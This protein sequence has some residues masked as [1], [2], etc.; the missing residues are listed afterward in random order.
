MKMLLSIMGLLLI[1]SELH[2]QL[3]VGS[4]SDHLRYNKAEKIAVSSDEIFASTGSSILVYNKEF[5][6][7][8]KLSPVTGLSETGIS[9]IAWSVQNQVLII[10]YNSANIDLVRENT[11]FNIPEILNKYIPGEK[12]INRITTSGKYAFLATNF[13]IVVVDLIKKEIHDTW[14]PGPGPETN[15]VFD[16]TFGNNKVFAATAIGVWAGD[17]TSQG[18]A[19]FGN[20]DQE[21]SL[22][23]PYIKCTLVI[24]SGNKLY[25]NVSP[26]SSTGDSIFALD[27]GATLVSYTPGLLNRS[28]DIAP[29]GF[30]VSSKGLL[31]YFRSDGSVKSTI[32]SYGW[33][34]PD[35]SQAIIESNDIWLADLNFGLIKAQN[36]SGFT[37]LTLPGPASNYAGNITY[38]NNTVL[39]SAGGADNSWMSLGRAFQV[40]LYESNNFTNLVPGTVRD[41]MRACIDPGNNGHFFISSW[42]D[43]LFEYNNNTLVKHFNENNTPELA[44][45]SGNTGIRICGL[46]MDRSKNLWIAQTGNSATIKVLKPDGSWIVNPL[47]I[48]APVAGDIIAAAN[49]QKWMVLPMGYSMF[50]LDDNNTPEVFTDDTSG[51]LI[52]KDSDEKVI[53][54][55]FS[56]A[57][58]LDGNI[59]IGTDQGPIIY[60]NPDRIFEIDARGERIKVPRND[61]S[62][63]A[64]YMLGT[65]TITSISIDGANRKWLGTRSSGVYLLSADGT[66]M[67]K[68]YNT[69]N[70]PL[71]SD[72]I[73]SVAVDNKT[74]EVWFGT[75]EGVLSVREIAISGEQKFTDVYAFPNP[76]RENYD[77]KVTI[78]GLVRDSRVKITNISGD[79]VY[80]TVSEGGQAEWDLT[81]Y[82]GNRVATGVYLVFCSGGDGSQSFVT[83]I[84]VIGR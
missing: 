7:L 40:S 13:G 68:N 76:V 12:K 10:G 55:V 84:L 41:A 46:A 44:I 54:F 23:D 19:Y 56:V 67:L 35:I 49:G 65:E 9:A 75:A 48:D 63:L 58:D 69:Q 57:E 14:R 17:I 52:I 31:R 74:G 61:G 24:Y 38:G 66:K 73:A 27:G 47:T 29:E 77:G 15:E 25:V 59:W 6:E 8:K 21:G 45:N 72:S 30:T 37:N 60:Y 2:C 78:T 4:W 34:V 82:T 50:I 62:G 1:V 39:I 42:G 71:F 81:T 43:G 36:M 22:P 11:V 79:L 70:S 26:G 3:P 64:D 32:S 20:W 33:G 16:I 53:S 51:K 28:F 18:L 5:S 83:K 80:E